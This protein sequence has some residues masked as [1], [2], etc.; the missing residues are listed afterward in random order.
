MTTILI[1]L[2][3]IYWRLEHWKMIFYLEATTLLLLTVWINYDILIILY[4]NSLFQLTMYIWR[5]LLPK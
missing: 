5:K 4:S 1:N 2:L 3:F